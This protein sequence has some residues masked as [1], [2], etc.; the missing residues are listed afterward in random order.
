MPLKTRDSVKHRHRRPLAQLKTI[1]PL[2]YNNTPPTILSNNKSKDI[3]LVLRRKAKKI[4]K[5]KD[6]ED[7][8]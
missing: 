3:P 1:K 6:E 8:L 2:K 5:Y 4:N 7:E